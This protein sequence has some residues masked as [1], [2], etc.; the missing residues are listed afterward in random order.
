MDKSTE[1]PPKASAYTQIWNLI[2]GYRGLYALAALGLFLATV[3]QFLVPL[4]GSATI[5]FVLDSDTPE[6]NKLLQGIIVA[7]GGVEN[8]SKYL[9]LPAIS[10]I[11]YSLVGG[12]FN[13]FHKMAAAR[14]SDGICKRLKDQLYDHIQRLSNKYIDGTQT[15]DLVQRCTSDIETIRI[16][17]A[18]H[19]VEIGRALILLIAVIPI[20]LLMNAWLTLASIILIP[21]IVWFGYFYFKRVKNIYKEVD[22][23]EGRLTAL[24]QENI[25]G[26]RVVRAFGKHEHEIGRFEKPNREYRDTNLR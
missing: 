17:L 1:S 22:E 12:I 11:G 25:T 19:V 15:G 13:Y 24:V 16:F 4:I 7:I 21:V 23:A 9:W 5:D 26:I 18:A 3:A 10:M 6:S 20:M 2:A 14:A 8:I